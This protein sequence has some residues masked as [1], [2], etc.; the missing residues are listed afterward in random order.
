M[1]HA[2]KTRWWLTEATV[3]ARGEISAIWA[4]R[5]QLSENTNKAI[6]TKNFNGAFLL[7][8]IGTLLDRTEQSFSGGM[9]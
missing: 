3:R 6:S 2:C 1:H 4:K 9:F 5:Q 8:N 7:V